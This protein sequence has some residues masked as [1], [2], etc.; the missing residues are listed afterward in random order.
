MEFYAE[1]RPLCPLKVR[2]STKAQ[3]GKGEGLLK[4][5]QETLRFIKF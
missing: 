2:E 3:N 1:K 5:R 4:D